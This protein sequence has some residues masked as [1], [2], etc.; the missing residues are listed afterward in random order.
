MLENRTFDLLSDHKCVID[1]N[2]VFKCHDDDIHCPSLQKH[3]DLH[4]DENTDIRSLLIYGHNGLRNRLALKLN[5]CDMLHVSWDSNLAEL[6]NR[7]HR[8]CMRRV[9]CEAARN[10]LN[11]AEDRKIGQSKNGNLAQSSYFLKNIYATNF[12]EYA[13]GSWYESHT[14]LEYPTKTKYHKNTYY[15]L[16]GINTFTHIIKP[17]MHRL[18][19]SYSRFDDGLSLICYYFPF[20]Y[21]NNMILLRQKPKEYQ[22]PYN[23]PL[24]DPVFKGLCKYTEYL[25]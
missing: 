21:K 20:G 22:C 7:H 9:T 2:G 11:K 4:D 14:Q 3:F 24:L 25:N 12:I 5:I 19:C 18:G 23:F 16:I 10:H 8:H 15:K 1:C 13:V 6:A 17:Q